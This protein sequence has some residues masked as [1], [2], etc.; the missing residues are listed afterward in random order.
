MG[1]QSGVALKSIDKLGA[2]DSQ[3]KT[4]NQSDEKWFVAQVSHSGEQEAI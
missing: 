3:L 4:V 2:F 1:A